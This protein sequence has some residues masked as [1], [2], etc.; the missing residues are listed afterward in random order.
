MGGSQVGIGTSWTFPQSLLHEKDKKFNGESF[1]QDGGA[2]HML[3]LISRTTRTTQQT[4][5]QTVTY[6][7]AVLL[8]PRKR[9]AH[10]M[11]HGWI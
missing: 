3:L 6:K 7:T 11:E 5:D 1:I 9:D 8:I 10:C 4:K 2:N